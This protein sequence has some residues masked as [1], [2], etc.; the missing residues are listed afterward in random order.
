MSSSSSWNSKVPWSSSPPTRSRPS[1]ILAS[2]SASR[3]SSL[4]RAR[5]CA[6]D[7]SMSK[8]ARR[9]SKE[10]EELIRRKSGSWSSPKRD[11]TRSL[12]SDPERLGER[13][14]DPL[15]LLLGHG[16]EE[17]PR[18]PGPRERPRGGGLAARIAEP[19]TLWRTPE[20]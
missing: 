7:C 18:G 1:E 19:P 9:Q 14:A 20:E 16:G 3:I 11:M 10:I 5:A 8:D 4:A 2:S 13:R 17:R 15:D 6:F 12:G